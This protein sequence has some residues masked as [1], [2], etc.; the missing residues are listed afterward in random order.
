M[1]GINR[2]VV[3]SIFAFLPLDKRIDLGSVSST[4]AQI[5]QQAQV[6]KK[7]KFELNKTRRVA[8]FEKHLDKIKWSQISMNDMLPPE[9]F[10]RHEDKVDWEWISYNTSIPM[11]F[12]ETHLGELEKTLLICNPAVPIEFFEAH[13]EQ[14]F[15]M[16][17]VFEERGDITSDNVR[18]YFNT[19]SPSNYWLNE[20][21]LNAYF[22][23]LEILKNISYRVILPGDS[24]ETEVVW[25]LSML[26][27]TFPTEWLEANIHLLNAHADNWWLACI[28]G[29]FPEEF[30]ER[31]LDRVHWPQLA[32]N[33]NLSPEFFERHLEE[34]NKTGAIHNLAYNRTMPIEFFEKHA[35]NVDWHTVLLYSKLS[36]DFLNRHLEH[37]NWSAVSGNEFTPV[38]FLEEHLDKIVW[39]SLCLGLKEETLGGLFLESETDELMFHEGKRRDFCPWPDRS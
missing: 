32:A 5:A 22:R 6:T 2:D 27:R 26:Y 34:L 13:P 30:F 1:A 10:L 20:I 16:L 21:I 4:L 29:D 9:F 23:K 7:E 39:H 24:E 12:L 3:S 17:K 19:A 37:L 36:H 33:G 31:H 38:E 11:E 25:S 15:N 8:F 18:K 14:K 28:T 35:R